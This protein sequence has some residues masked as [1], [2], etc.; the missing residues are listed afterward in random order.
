M[1]FPLHPILPSFTDHDTLNP[2]LLLMILDHLFGLCY[3]LLSLNLLH[4]PN[5]RGREREIKNWQ[6]SCWSP[7][8]QK[9]K[10]INTQQVL[11]PLSSV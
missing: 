7:I 8:Y 4:E 2:H 10:P 1:W 3:Q 6:L 11:N 9:R 5:M